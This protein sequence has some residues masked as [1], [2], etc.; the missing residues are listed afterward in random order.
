MSYATGHKAAMLE[1]R[2]EEEKGILTRAQLALGLRLQ[3]DLI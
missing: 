1:T 3:L 2:K